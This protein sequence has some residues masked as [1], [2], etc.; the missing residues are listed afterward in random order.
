MRLWLLITLVVNGL[1]LLASAGY[2]L[3]IAGNAAHESRLEMQ[4]DAQNL[5]L[6]IAAVTGEDLLLG[7]YDK[8][9]SRLLRMATIG[10][11]QDL[12]VFDRD[13]HRLLRITRNSSEDAAQ[14]DYSGAAQNL[15]PSRRE[16]LVPDHSYTVLEPIG[17]ASRPLGWIQV[18]V[19]LGELVHMRQQIW[20]STMLAALTTALLL[21][22]ILAFVIRRITAALDTA[23]RFASDL[24]NQ[25][26]WVL[27]IGSR[28]FEIDLLQHALN[29][30]SQKLTAQY[31]ALQDS[32]RRKTA[33]FEASLDC[34][35]TMDQNGRIVEFNPRAELTFGWQRAEVLGA[36]L[37]EIMVPMAHR[38]AHER[39][40][41]HYLATGA[42]PVLRKNIE[43]TALRGDGSEFAVELS[44]VP[45]QN[46]GAEFF[47]VSIR[48][49]SERKLLESK[50]EHVTLQLKQAMHGMTSIQFA[51]DQHAIVSK[52]DLQ[53]NITYINDKFLH[54]SGYSSGEL[55]GRN[56]R[57]LKSGL[58][59]KSFYEDMW[60]TITGG[61]VW[62]GNISNRRKG[63][64][65]YW[66]ASTIV[67]IMGEDGIPQQY[68]SV[69]TD[70]TA[71]KQ[72]EASLEMAHQGLQA[73]VEKYRQ[74][75]IEIEQAHARELEIGSQIQRTLLFGS[76]PAR[77]G[78]LEL[79]VY[80][81]ASKGVNGDFYEF[82]SYRPEICDLS[83]GDVMGKGIPAA[84]IGAAVKRQLSQ[85]MAEELRYSS[86][87]ACIPE[88]VQLINALHRHVTPQLYALESF[89]TLCYLRFDVER[90]RV[91]L[92]SAGHMPVLQVGARGIRWLSGDNLPL[93]V[94]AEERYVQTE[95]EIETGDLLFVYSDGYT[96]AFSPEGEAFGAERLGQR[97]SELQAAKIPVTTLLQ[98]V[99]QSIHDF[100]QTSVPS[101]DRTCLAIRCNASAAESPSELELPWRLD[102]LGALRQFI[103]ERA[104][105]A[106]LSDTACDALILA[107]YEA[108]TNVIRHAKPSFL[109]ARLLVRMEDTTTSVEVSLYYVSKPY[110]PL[111]REPDFSGES[112]GGFGLY[113]IENCVDVVVYDSPAESVVRVY[114]RKNKSGPANNTQD[115]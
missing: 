43:I 114:L 37:G 34:L 39:D 90:R 24:V 80:A 40:L 107:A 101:D 60:A 81:E 53:G 14:V 51:Q 54:V 23:T 62:H 38:A 47:L 92:V 106:G 66:V 63:G 76:V 57:L 87:T 3:Y 113:I 65:I 69:R 74:A 26:A 17:T 96:E 5:A 70:I 36:S 79:A 8:I 29:A 73:L 22:V 44:I 103:D 6:S 61:D 48:D 72:T 50:R 18:S 115:N 108:A 13:R 58:H 19:G 25:T 28:I 12:S 16:I 93:G 109:D 91:S 112:E 84:L 59:E 105:S 31:Q 20:R 15:D 85:V 32:E 86:T 82:F 67:P 30:A 35:V 27:P 45:F 68:I 78:P 83:T 102:A 71:Q 4:R 88:P 100:E 75:E 98:A 110:V 49:I 64:E 95:Y 21:S 104:R 111:P 56:H 99:R 33:M 42:G 97:V 1:I 10:S 52:S 46:Q 2:G 94:L 9:E 55:L 89:V 77:F 41:L 11:A 7:N